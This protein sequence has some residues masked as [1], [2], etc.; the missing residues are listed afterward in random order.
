MEIVRAL[1]ADLRVDPNAKAIQVGANNYYTPLDVARAYERDDV[2]AML[3][4]DPRVKKSRSRTYSP[5]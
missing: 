4:A 5:S 2:I 1:L 3:L